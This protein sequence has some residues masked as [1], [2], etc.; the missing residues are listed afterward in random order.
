MKKSIEQIIKEQLK[1]FFSLTEQEHPGGGSS[2]VRA[3]SHYRNNVGEYIS[4]GAWKSGGILSKD[5]RTKQKGEL[6]ETVGGSNVVGDGAYVEVNL[7]DTIPPPPTKATSSPQRGQYDSS[8]TAR[9]A[10][11][12]QSPPPTPNWTWGDP[13]YYDDGDS[14]WWIYPGDPNY[15]ARPSTPE[16]PKEKRMTEC[17]KKCKNGK[18]SD[19]CTGK[20]RCIHATISD[21]QLNRKMKINKW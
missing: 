5:G 18:W 17:C 16:P 4:G 2:K 7:K 10:H 21:C 15:P 19:K 13:Y 14:G 12:V 6:P 20:P 8:A 1:K 11:M 9:V 3:T